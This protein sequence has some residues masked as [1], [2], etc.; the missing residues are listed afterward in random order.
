M[1]DAKKSLKKIEEEEKISGEET[2]GLKKAELKKLVAKNEAVV[3]DLSTEVVKDDAEP[4]KEKS[5]KL[6]D[7]EKSLKDVDAK[8]AVEVKAL[9]RVEK[10]IKALVDP[11]KVEEE[12]D[13]ADKHSE[14]KKDTSA[15]KKNLAAIMKEEE[16]KEDFIEARKAKM[17]EYPKNPAVE[18]SEIAEAA[19]QEAKEQKFKD[20][21]EAEQ[22]LM[23]DLEAKA[24]AAKKAKADR[25]A[26]IKNSAELWTANMPSEYLEG[27]IQ[28]QVNDIRHQLA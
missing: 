13:P 14:P 9:D 4:V 15:F 17:E 19:A 18:A 27:Y 24:K 6:K 25:D 16:A 28:T 1:K 7:L 20:D 23:A 21:Y 11:P 12:V 8:E 10:K 5:A 26:A 3:A 22:K 2:E